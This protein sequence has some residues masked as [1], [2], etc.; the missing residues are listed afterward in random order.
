M[1]KKN[2]W[3]ILGIVVIL[4]IVI[5]IVYLGKL[6][7]DNTIKIGASLP[8]SGQ[9]AVYGIEIQNAIELA[10]GEINS[11]GGINGKKLEIIYEDDKADVSTGINVI[12][13]LVNIDN[14][15]V[16]LGS[17]A[18]GVV[19]AQAPIA[20][21]NKVIILA[22]ALSPAITNA[23]DYIFRIQPSAV[24]YTSVATEFLIE[25]NMNKSA[26][27]YVNNEFGKSLK[28]SFVSDFESRGGKVVAIESYSQGDTDFRAQ[29]IKIKNK[30]PD[31]IFIPGYQDTIEVIK[32]VN[33][34]GIKSKIL[35]GPPYESK[36]T[37]EKLGKLAEG[38]LYPS[39]FVLERGNEKTKQYEKEYLA[40]YNIKTGPYAPLMYDA[41]YI[42]AEALQ[43]CDKDT[44][45]IKDELY[46]MKY[47]G[48]SGDISF[49]SF[50]DPHMP[51]YMKTVKNGEFIEYS[52]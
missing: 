30:N 3:M 29:L 49:D 11:Q 17:W 14:V 37:T 51:I 19:V 43:K 26:V 27:I 2:I 18:S 9:N 32:Q 46:S 4:L 36:S 7:N 24:Y 47:S 31:V 38:V 40:R 5:G 6:G 20:E 16:V 25:H 50:G 21:K 1:K 10:R 44:D 22:D 33:E 8:L 23:G 39:H 41:T 34:L 48:V 35:A 13:K 12:N 52:E 28:D 15:P 42:I 45:C